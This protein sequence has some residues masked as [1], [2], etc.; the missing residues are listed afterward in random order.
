METREAR[1]SAMSIET[2]QGGGDAD[3]QPR[4]H[5]QDPSEG[6]LDEE[7]PVTRAHSQDPVEGGDDGS[8]TG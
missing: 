2:T 4:E 1:E 7:A 6:A 5:P 8:A 3:D